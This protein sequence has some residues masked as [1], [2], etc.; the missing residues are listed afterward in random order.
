[1]NSARDAIREQ[2]YN[3]SAEVDFEEDGYSILKE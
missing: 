3:I 1:M 2:F